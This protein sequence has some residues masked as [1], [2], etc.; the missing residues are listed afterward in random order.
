MQLQSM[1]AI[2]R[3]SLDL[4]SNNAAVVSQS[5][6]FIY[7]PWL[8]ILLLY[9]RPDNQLKDPMILLQFE[10]Y[11]ILARCTRDG[12]HEI[13]HECGCTMWLTGLF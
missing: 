12:T 8:G 13:I 7:D 10:I 1:S 6:K 3:M 4:F 5:L 9:Q 2:H 11:F